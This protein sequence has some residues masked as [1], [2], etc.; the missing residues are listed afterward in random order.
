MRLI[1]WLVT[2]ALFALAALIVVPLVRWVALDLLPLRWA[3]IGG[4]WFFGVCLGGA[5][6][7]WHYR[8]H[9]FPRMLREELERLNS[10]LGNG[11]QSVNDRPVARTR[12]EQRR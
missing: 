6:M 12:I 4:A 1:A 11:G 5:L 9:I 2:I 3:E 7:D 10:P 8:K